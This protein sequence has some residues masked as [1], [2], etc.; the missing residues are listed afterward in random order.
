[1]VDAKSIKSL[2]NEQMLFS[3]QMRKIT[4]DVHDLSD[5]L[6]NAK[7]VL[8][9]SDN[10]VWIEGLLIF[11]EVFKYLETT[12]STCT[13]NKHI[14]K[15]NLEDM[16][17]TAAFEADLNHYL[18]ADWKLDYKPR[19]SV[20][21]YLHHL[22]QLKEKDVTLLIAYV[23]HLYLGVLS[24]G[25]II[26]KKRNFSLFKSDY[27]DQVLTFSDSVNIG[28]LKRDVKARLDE[29]GDELSAD[30]KDALLVESREVFL[31]NNSIIKSISQKSI[32]YALLKK[33]VYVAVVAILVKKFFF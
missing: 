17:R 5:A 12:L 27:K 23:Y 3:K 4:R 6:V 7:L 31:L 19:E 21:K 32:N 20:V 22:E 11:Y 15:F 29:L 18:G 30:V 33:F 13:N 10:N 14:Q 1:M 8:A 28:Q 2:P 25:Q 9:M 16:K 24:G 26:N